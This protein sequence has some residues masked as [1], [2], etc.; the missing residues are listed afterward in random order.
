MD[1]R[2]RRRKKWYTLER[3]KHSK[4]AHNQKGWKAQQKRRVVK[5]RSEEL[6]KH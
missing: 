4:A 3:E 2:K 5:G 1:I 6:S